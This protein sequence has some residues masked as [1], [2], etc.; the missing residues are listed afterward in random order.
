MLPRAETASSKVSFPGSPTCAAAV[1]SRSSTTADRVCSSVSRSMRVPVLAVLFQSMRLRGSPGWWGRT[2]RRSK[3][4]WARAARVRGSWPL[5]RPPKNTHESSGAM[6]GST[7]RAVWSPTVSWRR[8]IPTTSTVGA[9][10]AYTPRR[11]PGI[12]EL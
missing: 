11:K 3:E 6:E 12:S 8:A 4:A 1:P 2:P 9:G 7:V 5:P 10:R